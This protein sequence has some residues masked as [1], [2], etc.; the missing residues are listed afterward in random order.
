M[1]IIKSLNEQQIKAVTAAPGPVLV[2]AGPGS[3][4]TRVLTH[5]AAYLIGELGIQPYHI[6]AVTFTNKAASEMEDRVTGLLGLDAH[7]LTLGTFHSTC[8][9]FLRM[10][11]EH[12]QVTPNYVIFDADDQLRVVKRIFKDLKINGDEAEKKKR[13]NHYGVVYRPQAILA[14]ISTAKNDLRLPEDL[15]RESEL[16]RIIAEVYLEYQKTLL[17]SNALDFDDLLMQFAILLRDN[18]KIREKYARRYQHIL[19]DEFQDT[20]MAQYTLLTQMASYH[21][22]I[23]VVG[24]PDQ[25]IYRWRGADYRNINRFER[26]Y[27]DAEV[28]LL[29]QNYRSTQNIL[30]T[31]MAIIDRNSNRTPK[32]L[33]TDRGPG[34]KILIKEA[35]DDQQQA[36]FV[37]EIISKQTRF[38][39]VSPA[40]FAV[41]YRTNAQSRILEEAFIKAEIPHKL[42]GA[43][44]FYGRREVKDIV[45]Y[46]RLVVNPSDIV[47]LRRVINTPRRKIGDKTISRLI[48]VAESLGISPGELILRLGGKDPVELDSF[49]TA[50]ARSLAGFGQNLRRWRENFETLPPV[51]I[52]HQII[53]DIE[54]R[55]YL[56]NST[57]EGFER[58]ENVVELERIA[59]ERQ[60]VGLHDFLERVTLISDQDTIETDQDVATL[61][62]LHAAKGLEFKQ[63]LI[64][65]VNED[66][67]PHQRSFGDPEAMEEERRLF[68]VGITRAKD[69]LM[70][71]HSLRRLTYEGYEYVD[72]SRYYEDI[73]LEL[74]T[75]YYQSHSYGSQPK[76]VTTYSSW[77]ESQ[78]DDKRPIASEQEYHPGEKVSH[79]KFGE[80]LVINSELRD[81][82]EI[83]TIVFEGLEKG[84]QQRMFIAS[85][86]ELKK[87]S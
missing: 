14:E 65:G 61:L 17:Q 72:A 83:V 22:N 60:T 31:A 3:G 20:N 48:S 56:E 52:V 51:E 69:R 73:P 66:I 43:Q 25:S 5:R 32:K 37:V 87:I 23:F 19:V 58:W 62:T 8:A 53:N 67:I 30:D 39:K 86:V 74:R 78:Q 47:S 38:N 35:Y 12:L 71:F 81:D 15:P 6:L 7:G 55:E 50:A 44:R 68:Y 59:N 34:E 79:S 28:I 77:K 33:F 45:A 42:V 85:L 63:V 41:M 54:Y 70:L 76:P 4:K 24:D 84:D 16:E 40:E 36:E 10:E 26:D 75:E 64:V 18:D 13:E 11:A 57:K 9:R 49:S 27:Q 82:D 1:D 46:L 80:G 29:E 21:G 2:L